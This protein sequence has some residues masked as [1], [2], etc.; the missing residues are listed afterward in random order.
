MLILQV[1]HPN[2]VSDV[3]A[4]RYAE[5]ASLWLGIPL[6]R[7]AGE[8]ERTRCVCGGEMGVLWEEQHVPSLSAR[9]KTSFS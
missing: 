3:S 1:S 5:P 4:V 6:G 2:L 8:N 9:A 7:R